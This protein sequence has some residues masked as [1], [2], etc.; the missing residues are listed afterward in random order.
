MSSLVTDNTTKISKDNMPDTV[1]GLQDLISKLLEIRDNFPDE[2]ETR[3][4]KEKFYS[5]VGGMEVD[6]NSFE[7][8]SLEDVE[9]A[10]SSTE[11]LKQKK[12]KEQEENGRET[13]FDK[14][15]KSR[16]EMVSRSPIKINK[17][18]LG[19]KFKPIEGAKLDKVLSKRD[20]DSGSDDELK[21]YSP[22]TEKRKTGGRRRTRGKK[23]TR[24]KRKKRTKKRRKKRYK[25]KRK[26]KRKRRR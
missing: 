20:R 16:N 19:N 8:E 24:K 21:L 4:R 5:N 18:R 17:K 11:K 3:R 26:S 7:F 12:E 15:L 25:F 14:M 23:R 22:P 9:E 10:I 13:N 6:I 1:D 2:E